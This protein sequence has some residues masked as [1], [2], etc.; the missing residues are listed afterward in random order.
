MQVIQSFLP[1]ENS[2]F[3]VR[4][5][6]SNWLLLPS[7]VVMRLGV[8]KSS[9]TLGVGAPL[10][11]SDSGWYSTVRVSVY[12]FSFPLK[13]RRREYDP[14]VDADEPLQSISFVKK[15]AKSTG[16]GSTISGGRLLRNCQGQNDWAPFTVYGLCRTE[17]SICLSFHADKSV[18]S[19]LLAVSRHSHLPLQVI[20]YGYLDVLRTRILGEQFEQ[21]TSTSL[22]RPAKHLRA[23]CSS[24]TI[25]VIRNPLIRTRFVPVQ[26]PIH[27]QKLTQWCKA[28]PYAACPDESE[29]A[30]GLERV[31]A[32]SSMFRTGSHRKNLKRFPLAQKF[33]F[34]YC[35]P[36]RSS[37]IC[38]DVD[39]VEPV[40]HSNSVSRS[41]PIYIE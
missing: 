34:S 33:P 22:V 30:N 41:S 18:R 1:L 23:L 5:S 29:L 19:F 27:H 39:K 25:P 21:E 38:F 40:W 10:F 7:W 24:K 4:D 37:D 28:I 13:S 8:P 11:R 26:R 31:P 16:Y 14:T 2:G 6:S 32:T 12:T 17:T 9:G 15:K 20:E 36:T 3:I 35:V